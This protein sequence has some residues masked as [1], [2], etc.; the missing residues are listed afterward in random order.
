[1]SWPP[2]FP[3]RRY[4]CT[5]PGPGLRGRYAFAPLVGAATNVA[6][7]SYTDVLDVGINTDPAA[8]PDPDV[9]LSCFDESFAELA[10]LA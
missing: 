10:K 7:L 9:L 8:I 6:L 5:W 1:M 4:P 3:D 2:T